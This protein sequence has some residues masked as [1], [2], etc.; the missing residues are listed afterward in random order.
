MIVFPTI[1]QFVPEVTTIVTSLCSQTIERCTFSA[2]NNSLAVIN[3]LTITSNKSSEIQINTRNLLENLLTKNTSAIII[4]HNHPSGKTYPSNADYHA[5]FQL[6]ALGDLLHFTVLD[7]LIITQNNYY[8]FAETG[9]LEELKTSSF[10][11][12]R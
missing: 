11:L 7:H 5:T 1:C 2:I 4:I 3:S 8:S 9:I 10:K 12:L 6:V